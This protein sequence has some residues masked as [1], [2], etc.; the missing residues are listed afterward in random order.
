MIGL[1]HWLRPLYF[2]L[3]VVEVLLAIMVRNRM[4]LGARTD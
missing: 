1:V 3:G 4:D 2:T